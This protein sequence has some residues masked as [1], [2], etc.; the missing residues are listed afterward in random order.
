MHHR[1]CALG[2][3]YPRWLQPWKTSNTKPSWC[4]CLS[5]SYDLHGV[6]YLFCSRLLAELADLDRLGHV[7]ND[8]C[9]GRSESAD[10]FCTRADAMG[11]NHYGNAW[12]CPR[13]DAFELTRNSTDYP[14]RAQRR[15]SL[16]A[17][18]A[19][20][21]RQTLRGVS[22]RSHFNGWNASSIGVTAT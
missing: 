12:S 6:V 10:P 16:L 3:A 22:L 15:A 13:S 9:F 18:S 4:G 14:F 21:S 5:L 2:K 8:S 11:P 7:G 19:P 20:S 1:R 17:A